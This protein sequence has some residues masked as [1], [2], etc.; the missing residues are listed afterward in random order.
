MDASLDQSD[1]E[2]DDD[3]DLAKKRK[4]CQTAESSKKAPGYTICC[5]IQFMNF[6]FIFLFSAG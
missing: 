1:D 3:E 5:I 2:E 4:V 6:S